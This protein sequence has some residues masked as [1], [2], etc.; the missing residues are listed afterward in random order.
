MVNSWYIELMVKRP[1]V[2]HSC[3]IFFLY[4]ALSLHMGKSEWVF[5]ALGWE[6]RGGRIPFTMQHV[7]YS[8]MCYEQESLYA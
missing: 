1:L 6:G 2:L 4:K 5:V 8:G 3:A 7:M